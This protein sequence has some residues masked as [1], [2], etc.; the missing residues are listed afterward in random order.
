[1]IQIII[2][3]ARNEASEIPLAVNIGIKSGPKGSEH[4]A[5]ELERVMA[6]QFMSA[7]EG[8]QRVPIVLEKIEKATGAGSSIITP[9]GAGK[10][11]VPGGR[12]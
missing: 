12:V 10:L 8:V 5:T 4:E 6:A 3:I 1:M 7:V 9:G 2:T 11:M